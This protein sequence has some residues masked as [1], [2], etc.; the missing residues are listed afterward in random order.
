MLKRGSP[1]QGNSPCGAGDLWNNWM[2]VPLAVRDAKEIR[3]EIFDYGRRIA[4]VG[5]VRQL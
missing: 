3:H 4:S 5:R 2:Q 1:K